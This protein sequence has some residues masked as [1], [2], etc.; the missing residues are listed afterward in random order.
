MASNFDRGKYKDTFE[1]RYGSGAYNS[2]LSKARDIGVKKAQAQFEETKFKSR[3]SEVKSEQKKVAKKKKEEED[4]LKLLQEAKAAK[5]KKKDNSFMNKNVVKPVKDIFSDLVKN[6]KKKSSAPASLNLSIRDGGSIKTKGKVSNSLQK[7]SDSVNKFNSNAVNKATGSLWENTLLPMMEAFDDKDKKPSEKLKDLFTGNLNGAKETTMSELITGEVD[8]KPKYELAK[9]DSKGAR[10]AS[11]LLGYGLGGA[12]V[13]KALRTVGL[14]ANAGSKALSVKGALERGKEGAAIG[15]LMSGTEVGGRELGRPD[16]YNWKQNLAQ[17]G[18]ETAGGAVLDPLLSAGGTLIGAGG[19]KLINKFKQP[20]KGKIDFD[21]IQELESSELPFTMNETQPVRQAPIETAATIQRP[22]PTLDNMMNVYKGKDVNSMPI[23]PKQTKPLPNE[24]LEKKLAYWRNKNNP[25][26]EQD[27]SDIYKHMQEVEAKT[28]RLKDPNSPEHQQ[29]VNNYA[30]K[31]PSFNAKRVE[32]D[33]RRSVLEDIMNREQEWKS[34]KSAQDEFRVKNRPEE[35]KFIVP[36]DE[37]LD[38]EAVPKRFRGSNNTASMDIHEAASVA[39]YDSVDD[40]V[41]YLQSVDSLLSKTRNDLKL[42]PSKQVTTLV[43]NE[44]RLAKDVDSIVNRITNVSRNEFLIEELSGLMTPRKGSAILS[45][46]PVKDM[47]ANPYQSI[48]EGSVKKLD[49]NGKPIKFDKNKKF[50]DLADEAIR[51]SDLWKD[52]KPLLYGRETLERNFEDI[53]GKEDA[54]FLKDNYV[55]PVRVKEAERFRFVN[56]LRKTVKSF[57]V[58]PKSQIDKLTQMYGEGKINLDNLKRE[59]P[60]WKKVVETA[61]WYRKTYDDL[62]VTV[63]KVLDAAGEKM[64]PVRADYFPHYQEID[65]IFNKIKKEFGFDVENNNLP[66]DINGLTQNYKPNK[67]WFGNAMQ[68]KTDETTFG[69]IEGF[70]RYIEGVSQ[71]IYHTDNIKSLRALE[72]GLRSKHKESE[73]LTNMMPYLL[74]QGNLMAGK[75]AAID[76]GIEE[77]VGRGVY[78]ALDTIKRKVGLNMLGYSFSSATSALIPLTQAI[79]TTSKKAFARGMADTVTN[80]VRNDGFT[81][82]SDFLTRRIGSKPLVNTLVGK[83]ENNSMAMMDMV[84][85]FTSQT[86]VRGKYYELLDKGIPEAEALKQADNWAGRVMTDRSKGQQPTLFATRALGPLMQFQVEVNNQVSFILKDIP[87]NAKNKAQ[88]V[89]QMTQVLVFSYLYNEAAEKVLGRRPAF[90]PAGV[91][92][93]AYK[94]FNNEDMGSKEATGKLLKGV[95]G[96]LPFTATF[97]GGRYPVSSAIPSLSIDDY[98]QGKTTLG[99]EAMK[100]LKYLTLPTGGGQ[101]NKIYEGSKIL[102]DEGV[103]TE[104]GNLKYPVDNNTSN[105]LKGLVLGKSSFPETKE[106]YD[107]PFGQRKALGS[108]QTKEYEYA[109]SKGLGKEFYDTTILNRKEKGKKNKL[110]DARE[111]VEEIEKDT[112]LSDKERKKRID[113]IMKSIGK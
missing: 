83:V 71:L 77:K 96:Q 19:K 68:R 98:T 62:I 40:Y 87:R 44:S 100:P 84:D 55:E 2:G 17:I 51:N 95:A 111:E 11:D 70:D 20:R 75:K 109:K 49:E 88:L 81:D 23:R 22:R 45:N 73:H 108:N 91:A 93:D 36:I 3:M 46:V 43:Q 53:A 7:A 27:V 103:Y 61:E 104:S 107:K 112:T 90:D 106:Y 16:D 37:R 42:P 48:V 9:P 86:I 97:T 21:D 63:N 102:N 56:D 52:K 12:G 99:K 32:L 66:T 85:R 5:D 110:N 13:G 69:A 24:P 74:E 59:T 94:N 67:K 38:Y 6:D 41:R 10:L 1:K 78:N 8:K 101:I 15:A 34:V 105:L 26:D 47:P 80:L 57:G 28:I 54:Q 50:N 92:V 14:G 76:R 79:A 4:N 39:G 31:N 72:N 58:K 89:S 29:I 65:G 82:K 35:M 25:I 113:K 33:K 30:K 18:I 64:I 60:D